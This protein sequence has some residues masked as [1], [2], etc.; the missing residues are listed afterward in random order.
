MKKRGGEIRP[1]IFEQEYRQAF[2]GIL[3]ESLW[4]QFDTVLSRYSEMA[5]NKQILYDIQNTIPRPLK[6][7]SVVWVSDLF[8]SCFG[9]VLYKEGEEYV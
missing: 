3:A 8:F 1:C 9:S 6:S 5:Q 7:R 4:A 2:K